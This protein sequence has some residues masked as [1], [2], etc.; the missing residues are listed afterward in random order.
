MPL[1][2]VLVSNDICSLSQCAFSIVVW[3]GS[4][5]Y[6]LSITQPV[7]KIVI[8][9]VSLHSINNNNNT[10]AARWSNT[11]RSENMADH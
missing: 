1:L 3:D 11:I 8:S 4:V 2:G 7:A 5:F 9:H 10:A 6:H